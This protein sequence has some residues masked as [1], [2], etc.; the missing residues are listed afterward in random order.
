MRLASI[1]VMN[2]IHEFFFDFTEFNHVN[3]MIF[4]KFIN[5]NG[6]KSQILSQA[7]PDGLPVIATQDGPFLV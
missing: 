2:E 5:Y 1:I 3:N 4:Q 6:F 7:N